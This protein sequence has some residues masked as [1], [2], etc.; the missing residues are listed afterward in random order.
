MKLKEINEYYKKLSTIRQRKLP[1]KVAYAVSKNLK[2]MEVEVNALQE[3]QVKL[4][5]DAAQKKEDGTPI[6]E[7]RVIAGKIYAE[8]KMDDKDKKEI[9][10]QLK[11][12]LET[13]VEIDVKKISQDDLE[14]AEKSERYD[15][16]S[17]EDVLAIDFMIE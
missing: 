2:A 14:T 13:D 16:L 12:L 17:I 3:A 1:I 7:E 15:A 8:Y 10:Q 4:C 5:E 9:E 11:D 6:V